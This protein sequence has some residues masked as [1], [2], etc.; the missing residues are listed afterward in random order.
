MVFENNK[1]L[2]HE[3]KLPFFREVLASEELLNTPLKVSW[4]ECKISQQE[5]EKDVK[6]IRERFTPLNPFKDDDDSD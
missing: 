5:E 3:V 6:K 2:P 4:K 1:M